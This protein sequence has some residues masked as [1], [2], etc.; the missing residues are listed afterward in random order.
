M[1][2]TD[3]S[4]F[5]ILAKNVEG[6]A[7]ESALYI[8]EFWH[9]GLDL[10]RLGKGGAIVW[11]ESVGRVSDALKDGH[12]LGEVKVDGRYAGRHRSWVKVDDLA[13]IGACCTAQKL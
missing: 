8:W 5:R 6:I 11:I 13:Y 12:V 7:L 9:L 1:L 4:L 10:G 3:S 2:E